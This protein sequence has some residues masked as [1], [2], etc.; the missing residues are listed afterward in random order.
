MIDQGPIAGGTRLVGEVSLFAVG[1]DELCA[2]DFLCSP[3]EH[4]Q[5]AWPHW[6]HCTP[7]NPN[8]HPVAQ[9]LCRTTSGRPIQGRPAIHLVKQGL[10]ACSKLAGCCPLQRVTNLQRV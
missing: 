9:T 3:R 6:G 5:P 4:S 10:L 2:N 7:S 1:G 8:C